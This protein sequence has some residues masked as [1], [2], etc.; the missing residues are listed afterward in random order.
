[1]ESEALQKVLIRIPL[2][3]IAY[4]AILCG[5]IYTMVTS[6]FQFN[7]LLLQK[8]EVSFREVP[9]IF[10]NGS[11]FVVSYVFCIS[12]IEASNR[13]SLELK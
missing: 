2:G 9:F 6:L 3:Y 12:L 11:I 13:E 8:E 7:K 10:F 5:S 4:S 1:M